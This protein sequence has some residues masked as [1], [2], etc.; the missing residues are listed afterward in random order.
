MKRRAKMKDLELAVYFRAPKRFEW[1][2]HKSDG[3]VIAKG[4]SVSVADARADGIKA[5]PRR[6]R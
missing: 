4:L 6:K 2:L 1:R 5:I 3:Q